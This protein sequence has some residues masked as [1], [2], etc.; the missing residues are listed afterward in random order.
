MSKRLGLTM[1]LTFSF[2][3]SGIVIPPLTTL[4]AACSWSQLV[5][6]DPVVT[7]LILACHVAASPLHDHRSFRDL[8][9][10]LGKDGVL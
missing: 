5:S 4:P 6:P 10:A 3:G 2:S 7:V 8:A 1:T 9:V